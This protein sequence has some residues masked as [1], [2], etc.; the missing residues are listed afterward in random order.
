MSSVDF[1]ECCHKLLKLQ[2]RPGQEIELCNMVL[3]CCMQDRTYLG[4][5]GHVAQRFCKLSPVYVETYEQLF[6]TQF[7]TVHRLEQAKLRNLACFFA[8]LFY[9]QS[10]AYETL[11]CI[12][13]TEDSTTASSRIFVKILMQ[14]IANNLGI[15]KLQEKLADPSLQQTL[16]GIFRTDSVQNVRFSIN[17]FTS[18]GLGALTESMR[19]FLKDAPKLLLEKKY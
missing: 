5:Y 2:I 14:E 19:E 13:L 6:F 10:I 1:E 11:R 18:I 8:Q 15:K 3:E 7:E 17:F 4:Y 9:T 16:E 12:D